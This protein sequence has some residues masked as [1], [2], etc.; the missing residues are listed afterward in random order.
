MA[1][2]KPIF[3]GDEPTMKLW[4]I[5]ND[6]SLVNFASG[7][8]FQA[9]LYRADDATQTVLFTKTTG[10]T[11]AAGTGTSASGTPNL[12][13]AFST[14]NDFN[15]A[16]LTAGL[17]VLQVKATDGSSNELTNKVTFSLETRV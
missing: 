17:H 8:T 1:S 12:T 7:Y 16:G 11:G 14:T 6:G 5:G 15:T 9:K 10:F 4:W 3:I 2:T 13:I